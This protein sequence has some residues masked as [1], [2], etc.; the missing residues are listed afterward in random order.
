ML[1][2]WEIKMKE[3]INELVSKIP[4]ELVEELIESYSMMLNEY[5][6]GNWKYVL[7][8][9]GKFSE[10]TF[11][12]LH[13]LR[14]GKIISEVSNLQEEINLLQQ[15]P[16]DKMPE[17]LR[18]IIPRVCQAIYTLRSKKDAVHVKPIPS[19]YI[20][21]TLAVTACSWILAE[22][23]RLYHTSEEK[24]IIEIINSLVSRKIPFIE[25]HGG[26]KFVTKRIGCKNEILLLLLDS[27]EGLSRKEI[28]KVLKKYSQSTITESLKELEAGEE[29]FVVYSEETRKYYI[30]G[31]GENY[32]TKLLSKMV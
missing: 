5:V 16:H 10:N 6:K 18:I 1:K 21:S 7:L 30:T 26:E 23:I 15:I 27:P 4:K 9:S 17:S 25:K 19:G 28:G 13:F 29:S 20:D 2:N 3:T 14:E 32:I 24:K 31:F 22:F 8:N 12:V 11:R